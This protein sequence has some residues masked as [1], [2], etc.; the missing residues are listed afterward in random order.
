MSNI[1]INEL[2][3]TVYHLVIVVTDFDYHFL[4]LNKVVQS[5]IFSAETSLVVIIFS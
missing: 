4:S 3:A 5:T 1:F 2:M